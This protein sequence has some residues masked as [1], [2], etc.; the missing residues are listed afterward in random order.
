MLALQILYKKFS[1]ISKPL[2]NLL[3]KIILFV[4]NEDCKTT[5][6]KLKRALLTPPIIIY[7][8][9]DQ[10]FEVVCDTDNNAVSAILGK[11][12]GN[13]FNIIYYET[14]TLIEA[15]RNMLEMIDNCML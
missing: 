14:H 13:R 11:Q 4:F 2:T 3:H 10:P 5:F 1:S 12:K 8:N 6:G 15:Q 9:W 7:Q